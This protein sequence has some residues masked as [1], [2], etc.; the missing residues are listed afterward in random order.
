MTAGPTLTFAAFASD[1]TCAQLP[2]PV[3]QLLPGLFLDYLRVASMGERMPWSRWARDYT[4]RFGG[5]GAAPVL[6][7]AARHDPVSAGFLNT[8]YAG[9]IDADD[10]HVGAMLHPGGIVFSAALAI[11]QD[12]RLPGEEV[13]AAVVAGYEAMIRIAL[14][15]QPSHFKRGFQSTATCGG[16]GAAVA[17]ARLLFRGADRA[18]RTAETIG[19]VASFSS[20]LA[21]FYHSGSTVK[22][23]HAAHATKEGLHAALLAEAGFSGPVDILEG[24]DGFAK[25]YA[26]R[27]DFSPLLTG[28]GVNY[29]ILEVAVKP[30][31]SSAR[32]LSAIEATTEL[33]RRHSIRVQDVAGIRLGV[34]SVIMGRLTLNDPGDLQAAQVSAPFCVAMTVNRCLSAGDGFAFGVEDFETGLGE[35]AVKDLAR[36]VECVLDDEVEQTSTVESV[37]AK[38]TLRLNSGAEHTA[39]VRAPKGSVSRPFTADEHVLRARFELGKR[40]NAVRCDEL[41]AMACD[42]AALSD[43]SAMARVLA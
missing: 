5:S 20:G 11:G 33:C 17:A 21:Q 34:P 24:K 13:L 28:L 23:I 2:L 4:T 27:V 32:L 42:L 26:D 18:R 22:R 40:Y 36:R 29:R 8:T 14:C 6:F 31:A 30:H 9:S 3:R 38:V 7:S 25:A 12:R 43:V 37:G 35:A 15:V 41:I 1:L 19:L 10:T 16:F 39:F